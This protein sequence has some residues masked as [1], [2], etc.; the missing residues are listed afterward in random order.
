MLKH[1]AIL[2]GLLLC[3][4]PASGL[5]YVAQNDSLAIPVPAAGG[6]CWYFPTS[7]Q[8]TLANMYDI[9]AGGAECQ[10]SRF[11]TASMNAGTY[12]FVYTYPVQVNGRSIKDVSY[13]NGQLVSIFTQSPAKDESGKQAMMVKAD[14]EAMVQKGGVDQV[15]EDQINVK[16]PYL[17]VLQIYQVADN[18]LRVSG[19]SNMND[20]TIVSVYVDQTAHYA[21]HNTGCFTF[22]TVIHRGALN[23]EGQYSVNMLLPLQDMAPGNHELTVYADGLKTTTSGFPITS[24][25]TPVP[26]PVQYINYFWNGSAMPVTVTVP[27]PG[28][29]QY[30]DRWNTATPTP[31]ITDALGEPVTYPYTPGKNLPLPV[32]IIALIGIAAVV[33]LRDY[34]RK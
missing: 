18:T 19:A 27:V 8:T 25:W 1:L 33:L 9:P 10:L 6:T 32:G 22:D 17:T 31:V 12:D 29:V 7:E 2:I 26:T 21:E 20:G 13:K 5:I 11:Q 24:W 16:A 28:P 4:L 15:Y 34:E 23:E 30:V 14:L 3:A